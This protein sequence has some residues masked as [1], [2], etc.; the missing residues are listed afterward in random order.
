MRHL[1]YGLIVLTITG[2]RTAAQA[3]SQTAT[4][5][6]ATVDSFFHLIEREKWDSAAMLVDV[7]RFEPYFKQVVSSARTALPPREQ[8][9]EE[10][11]ARDRTMPRA[12]AEWEMARS[13][14]YMAMAP[15]FG[16]MSNEFAGVHSQSDLFALT[17]SQAVARWLEAMDYRTMLRAA[18]LRK[19]CALSAVPTL[20]ATKQTLLAIG[21]A[22]DSVAYVIQTDDR[23]GGASDVYGEGERVLAVRRVRDQWRIEARRNLLRP[24]NVWTDVDAC[25]SPKKP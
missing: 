19:G 2:A 8:T 7:P 21:V 14:K 11:M 12:A 22:N 1:R 3:P 10:I 18:L 16:D 25:P 20:P 5:V 23:F 4:A 13:K 24:M 15:A 17:P 9:V 6:R